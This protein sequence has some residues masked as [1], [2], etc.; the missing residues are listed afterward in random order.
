[1]YII[2]NNESFRM[3]KIIKKKNTRYY[4]GT[5]QQI[6]LKIHRFII[7]FVVF[8]GFGFYIG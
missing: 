5:N 6:V 2:C 7:L 1:M 3:Q 4:N 8:E